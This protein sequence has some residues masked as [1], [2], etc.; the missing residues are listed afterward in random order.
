MRIILSIF[1]ISLFFNS[2]AQY[3]ITANYNTVHIGRN[4]NF[5]L[6][7]N[8]NNHTLGIALKYN[9]NNYVTDNQNEVFKKR[10]F[11]VNLIEHFGFNLDYQYNFNIKKSPITPFI[12][13]NFQFT[14]SHTRNQG[15]LKYDID[16]LSN[17]ILYREYLEFWGPT[18]AIENYLGFGYNADIN[19]KVYIINK[20]GF[21]L[22]SYFNVDNQLYGDG[23]N[24]EFGYMIS[25]GL[26][27][28]LYNEE[29]SP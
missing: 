6:S 22:I 1:F 17:T 5:G 14:N 7:R 29:K 8:I 16:T 27:Y 23:G 10:F 24:W 12:F 11:A 25:F 2:K 28:R 4:I 18:I 3:N 26:G 15:Y 21:G 19:K 9:I 13:Y 20:I